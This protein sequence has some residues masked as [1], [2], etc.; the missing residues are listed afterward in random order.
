MIINYSQQS[1]AVHSPKNG[2]I[3]VNKVPWPKGIFIAHI[4]TKQ[5]KIE[6]LKVSM[7]NCRLQ[8]FILFAVLLEMH[9]FYIL[10]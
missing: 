7:Q 9:I 5:N 6:L 10:E 8:R 1:I 3:D 4:S 2:L